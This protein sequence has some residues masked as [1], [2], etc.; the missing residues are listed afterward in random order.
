M[1]AHLLDG[2][3]NVGASEDKVLQSPDKT[4]ETLSTGDVQTS[5]WIR[6]KLP[7]ALEEGEEKES[8]TYLPN[9]QAWHKWSK[10]PRLQ[11]M[12]KLIDNFDITSRPRWPRRRCQVMDEVAAVSACGVEV[13]EEAAGRRRV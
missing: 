5:Q 11:E 8:L 4:P 12:T 6:S 9:W 10:E 3:G 7:T 13:E 1:K 2:A